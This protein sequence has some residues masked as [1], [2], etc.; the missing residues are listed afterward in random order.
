M[1]ELHVLVYCTAI[2]KYFSIQVIARAN[3]ATTTR[4]RY[5]DWRIRRAVNS[6]EF[7]IVADLDEKLLPM[8]SKSLT[9]Q[10]TRHYHMNEYSQCEKRLL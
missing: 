1:D 10:R 8:A 5:I 4:N 6:Q 7:L 9:E 2:S 3:N